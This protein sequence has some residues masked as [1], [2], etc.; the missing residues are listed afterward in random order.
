MTLPS[1]DEHSSRIGSARPSTLSAPSGVGPSGIGH[2]CA[3]QM[4]NSGCGPSYLWPIDVLF[5]SSSKKWL[6]ALFEELPTAG[7]VS[8]LN[9]ETP[10]LR[11]RFAAVN[12]LRQLKVLLRRSHVIA[13]TCGHPLVNLQQFIVEW[14]SEVRAIVAQIERE[15]LEE[16]A[17]LRLP[18]PQPQVTTLPLELL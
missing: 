13:V 3:L 4:T 17:D 15:W 2:T 9:E 6:P 5:R 8:V 7:E 11:S 1:Q 18:V 12:Q 16:T 10:P 14:A